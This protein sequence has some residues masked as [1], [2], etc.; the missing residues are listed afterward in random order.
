M[1]RLAVGVDWNPA[2]YEG[3]GVDYADRTALLE[4]QID[5]L[6][7]L[8]THPIVDFEG[9]FHKLSGVGLN[10]LPIHNIPLMIGS[11]GS[12]GFNRLAQPGLSHAEHLAA[13]IGAKPEIDAMVG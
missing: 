1:L 7:M 8:W 4:E 6:R 11:R 9:R 12:I 2:E 5:V 3:L 13:I 10:P